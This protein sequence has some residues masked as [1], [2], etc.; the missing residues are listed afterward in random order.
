MTYVPKGYLC[1]NNFEKN[2]TIHYRWHNLLIFYHA[3]TCDPAIC[4]IICLQ[5]LI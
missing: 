4:K 1:T 2:K 3:I 5:N